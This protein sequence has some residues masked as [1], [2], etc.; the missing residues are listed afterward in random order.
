[1]ISREQEQ[2]H[3]HF[4]RS[5]DL[6]TGVYTPRAAVVHR[7]DEYPEAGFEILSAIQERHFWYRGRHRFLLA[8]AR[9]LLRRTRPATAE[10]PSAVDLGGGCGSFAVH[11]DVGTGMG[12]MGDYFDM[13]IPPQRRLRVIDLQAHHIYLA[14]GDPMGS[15][16][17]V[18]AIWSWTGRNKWQC[19]VKS[20]PESVV[21]HPADGVSPGLD[22][23]CGVTSMR[24]TDRP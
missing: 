3:G 21:R 4:W 11:A 9:A 23:V 10:R 13:N 20:H 24:K 17:A 19:V 8:A 6:S 14:T 7:D 2:S 1:M 5:R 15:R 16:V 18:G 12:Y 22:R